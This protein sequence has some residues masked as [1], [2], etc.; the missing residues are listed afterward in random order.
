MIKLT[1]CVLY[2]RNALH[3]AFSGYFLDAVNAEAPEFFEVTTGIP[4]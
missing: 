4:S 2:F 3:D 1:V